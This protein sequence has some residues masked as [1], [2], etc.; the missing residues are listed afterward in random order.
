MRVLVIDDDQIVREMISRMLKGAGYEVLEATN[1][2]TGLAVVAS[3][4]NIDLVIT[5]I[6]MPEKEGIETIHELKRDFP[7]MKILAIS[8]GGKGES[9]NYLTIARSVGANST[10]GKPFVKQEL[11]DSVNGILGEKVA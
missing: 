5:D 8:G 11:L 6:I 2:A 3:G 1:G 7:E 4:I 10:L 9:K